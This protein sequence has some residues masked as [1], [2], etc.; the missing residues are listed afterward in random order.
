MIGSDE[1]DIL[2]LR[3]P[4]PT[5]KYRDCTLGKIL[6]ETV[7]QMKEEKKISSE[8]CDK[9]LCQ[10]DRSIL[11]ALS[12]RLTARVTFKASKLHTYRFLDGVWTFILDEVEFREHNNFANVPQV[13]YEL[14]LY[15]EMFY[16]WF[17]LK[18]LVLMMVVFCSNF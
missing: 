7:D 15:F 6:M 5:T 12:Q 18:N 8:L 2:D 16:F 17:Y 4:T 14:C 13:S 1:E 11:N 9:I 3:L 10:F